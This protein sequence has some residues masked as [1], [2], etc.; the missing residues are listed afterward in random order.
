MT[1]P[2]VRSRPLGLECRV[3]RWV[4]YW[5]VGAAVYVTAVGGVILSSPAY[6]HRYNVWWL[7]G[8]PLIGLGVCKLFLSDDE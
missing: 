6:Q 8:P 4:R 5:A 7:L 1:P 2:L 3:P